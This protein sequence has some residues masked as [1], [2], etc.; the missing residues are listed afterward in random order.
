MARR[1]IRT[2][3]GQVFSDSCSRFEDRKGYV[4]YTKG[5]FHEVHINKKAIISD[6]TSGL[7][8]SWIMAIAVFAV[9]AMVI[10]FLLI[11]RRMGA[12]YGLN[13]TDVMESPNRPGVVETPIPTPLPVVIASTK[14][15]NYYLASCDEYSKVKPEHKV[16]FNSEEDA[17][18]AGYKWYPQCPTPDQNRP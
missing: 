13:N 5:S 2:M 16:L 4:L 3:D 15:G 18:R 10:V 9:M 17:I 12:G 1:T 7:P 14:S 11:S 6:S 8:A